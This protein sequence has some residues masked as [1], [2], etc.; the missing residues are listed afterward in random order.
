MPLLSQH[1]EHPNQYST[2]SSAR[3]IQESMNGKKN[4]V[5]LNFG[6][7]KSY[8]SYLKIRAAKTR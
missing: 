3:R 7:S 1:I 4:L 2:P 5:K 8:I 6:K